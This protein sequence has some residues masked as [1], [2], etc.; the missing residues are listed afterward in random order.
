S[1]ALAGRSLDEYRVAFDPA[2]ERYAVS[3]A[4]CNVSLRRVADDVEVARLPR[5]G[6]LPHLSWI[7]LRFSPDGGRLAVGYDFD[8]EESSVHV[9]AVRG[10]RPARP[11]ALADASLFDFSPDGRRLAAGRS[12]GTIGLFDAGSG[13]ELGRLETGFPPPHRHFQFAFR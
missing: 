3:D 6:P 4:D 8:V 2:F 5:V 12:D 11:L 7:I 9:G 13:R 10:T 1:R